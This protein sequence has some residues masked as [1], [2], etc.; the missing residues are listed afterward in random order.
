M[1]ATRELHLVLGSR[2]LTDV[3]VT[4]AL[5]TGYEPYNQF[6][7]SLLPAN[8]S[9]LG[10]LAKDGIE[11]IPTIFSSSD[12]DGKRSW[13]SRVRIDDT[14]YY[15]Y[16]LL[17][18]E[19]TSNVTIAPNSNYNSGAKLTISGMNAVTA[20][21]VCVIVGVKGY[22]PVNA[23]DPLPAITANDLAMNTCLGKFDIQFA[24]NQ[25]NYAYLL[26][27]HL[28]SSLRFSM[29]IDETYSQLRTIKV[30]K[31]ELTLTDAEGNPSKKTLDAKVKLQANTDNTSP[32]AAVTY[33]TA[34]G[35]GANSATIFNVYNADD[36]LELKTTP[37]DI[38]CYLAPK[39][40]REI[41]TPK[42]EL[43]TT[44]DVYDRKGNLIRK[45]EK[46]TNKFS[47]SVSAILDLGRGE[48]YVYNI[49]V[50]PTYLYV[51]S[52]PDLDLP[53]FTIE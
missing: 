26:V 44:Y 1:Q 42:L 6:Y 50:Q 35:T 38:R 21:D 39:I 19:E 40:L 3:T 22:A 45:D 11:P 2:N 27:D 5:P 36:A 25:D 18:M 9:I 13:S 10:F 34:D 48:E 33:T 30:K 41:T 17:P 7:G 28:Y 20:N 43:Q 23:I 15:L 46:A 52:D 14:S 29:K 37:Q 8:A 12:A 51:L 24:D 31:M 49:T 47:P 16:G 53:T 4:R 32:L